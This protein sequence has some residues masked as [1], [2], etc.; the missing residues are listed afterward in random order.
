MKKV[1]NLTVWEYLNKRGNQSLNKRIRVLNNITHKS[2]G[3]WAENAL[4]QVKTVKITEKFLFI[5]I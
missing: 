4:A 3:N 5:F 1:K 2:C